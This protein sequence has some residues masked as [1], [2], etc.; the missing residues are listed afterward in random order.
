[1]A[2]SWI[3][4][5]TSI[6]IIF[7]V[8]F[9]CAVIYE[10]YTRG[11]GKKDSW[12]DDL[13]LPR[14]T[15]L[16]FGI[17]YLIVKVCV[18]EYQDASLQQCH[19][20][21]LAS[22]VLFAIAKYF[23]FVFLYFK[24]HVL[25]RQ[26]GEV[27]TK[28]EKSILICIQLILVIG[29]I[30]GVMNQFNYT[31]GVCVAVSSSSVRA[32]YGLGALVYLFVCGGLLYLF[33]GT[34]KNHMMVSST[35]NQQK[36]GS[37]VLSKEEIAKIQKVMLLNKQACIISICAFWITILSSIVLP[38]VADSSVYTPFNQFM[39]SL[40]VLVDCFVMMLCSPQI[41][42]SVKRYIHSS[43]DLNKGSTKDGGA[44]SDGKKKE[45]VATGPVP[46]EVHTEMTSDV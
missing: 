12:I 26:I 25:R 29:V 28:F 32:L 17:I 13:F 37:M 41:W 20:L 38:S 18:I 30:V 31:D 15:L 7:P 3:L 11:A 22:T 6:F 10:R 19:T 4:S 45:V 34:I 5:I 36:A 39:G 35:D 43:I 33:I 1:M 21:A 42:M 24:Q 40:D 2:A 46:V 8:L 14:N 27:S 44:S 9:L 16:V 23:V